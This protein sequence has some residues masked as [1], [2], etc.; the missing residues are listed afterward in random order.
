MNLK[1]KV[2]VAYVATPHSGYLKLFRSYG[3]GTLYILGNEFIHEFSSL[4]R[5]LPGVAPEEIQKMVRSLGI[6]KDVHILTRSN[7]HIVQNLCS[8]TMP[9]EDISRIFAEKYFPNVTVI[10]D[11]LWR[12]RWD[13]GSVQK[14]RRPEGERTISTNEF[15]RALMCDA[16]IIAQHSPDWWRQI[17]ALLVRNGK[18]LLSAFNRHIPNEQSAYCYGDPRSNFE[19]GERIDVSGALHAEMGIIVEVARLGISMEGCDLY[20]TTFPCPPCAYAVAFTGIKRL[21]YVDGYSLVSGAET[22]ETNNVEI[23]RVVM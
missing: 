2:L 7:L 6:F 18:I 12:L 15:D 23:I 8:I 11:S 14:S 5:N 9:E 1:P 17:G 16:L 22:L 13:W 20:V 19:A 4:V 10:F 21:F 3:G